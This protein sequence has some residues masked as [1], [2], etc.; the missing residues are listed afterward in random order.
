MRISDWSSDVC[1]SDLLAGAD[2]RAKVEHWVP[3][4]MAL[5]PSAYTARGGVGTVE[6]AA[7]V[8]AARVPDDPAPSDPAKVLA[9]PAPAP[10]LHDIRT[11][12]NRDALI[13]WDERALDRDPSD[14][15]R[16]SQN[17]NH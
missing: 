7:A 2:G 5:P 10:I 16:K 8:A 1:S 9:L 15:K 14:R 4:W 12:E 13:K 3:K 6:K 17:S 11:I